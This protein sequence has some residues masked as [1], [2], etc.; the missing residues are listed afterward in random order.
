MMALWLSSGTVYTMARKKKDSNGTDPYVR[1]VSNRNRS[2]QSTG[3]YV[4]GILR[5][6][7]DEPK[8]LPGPFLDLITQIGQARHGYDTG[9]FTKSQYATL[10]RGLRIVGPDG[11]EWTMGAT[12]GRWYCR[13]VGG[14][15]VPSTPPSELSQV[16]SE[17]ASPLHGNASTTTG[18]QQSV[19]EEDLFA[20]LDAVLRSGDFES[21]ASYKASDPVELYPEVTGQASTSGPLVFEQANVSIDEDGAW[22]T[23][24]ASS[25]AGAAFSEAPSLDFE[26]ENNDSSNAWQAWGIKPEQS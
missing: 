23:E 5:S 25:D 14:A 7:L 2:T 26:V 8:N 15:W 13:P 10:L 19:A 16:L 4:V 11:T 12:S 18:A 1:R 3:E 17:S 20:H 24:F 9:S 6:E 21:G 22:S